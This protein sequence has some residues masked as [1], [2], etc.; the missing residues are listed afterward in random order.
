MLIVSWLATVVYYALLAFVFMMWARLIVDFFR[1]VRP[2]WRPRSVLLILL[3]VV[4]F[5]TDPPIRAV[6]KFIKPVRAGAIALDFSW[7]VVLLI[8]IIAM[9]GALAVA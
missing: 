9:Y 5:F 4:Y 8:A 1:A 7:T 3:N 2:D 6:R